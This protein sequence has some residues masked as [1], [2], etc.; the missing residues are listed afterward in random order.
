[1]HDDKLPQ[2]SD[3]SVLLAVEHEP[4]AEILSDRLQRRDARVD[5]VN[6]GTTA[7]ERVAGESYDVVVAETRLAGRT[8]LELLRSTSYLRPPFVLLGRRGNDEEVVRA[9]EM[10]AADYITR[11]FAPRIAVARILRVSRLVRATEAPVRSS[12][13]P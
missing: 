4:S 10:G 9:F 11:P 12:S 6:D 1:M 2:A 8:G 3:L 5:R 13:T 7:G